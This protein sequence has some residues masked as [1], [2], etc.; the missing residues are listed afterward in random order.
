MEN[1]SSKVLD[2]IPEN[3]YQ[4]NCLR[5][6]SGRYVNLLDPQPTTIFP[7]DIA[8]GLS[9]VCRF[10]GHTKRFY[11]VAEH[12]DA[13][14]QECELMYPG[15]SALAFKVMM[16]DAHE[17]LLCDIPSPLK[18]LLPEYAFIAQ[19]L[20]DAIHTR[21]GI[22]V[23]KADAEII[24]VIDKKML[25]WEWENKVLRSTGLPLTEQDRSDIFIHHFIRLCKHPHVLV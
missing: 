25:E 10:A 9:R 23:T 19:K 7:F 22:S 1:T 5:T 18:N 3:L 13:C 17:Y 11:S 16:H 21:F 6:F 4:P 2:K 8:I 20:Q 24:K 14:R 15:E 12:A